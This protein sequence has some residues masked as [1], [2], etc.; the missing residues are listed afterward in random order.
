MEKTPDESST[1]SRAPLKLFTY[2]NVQWIRGGLVFKAHRLLCHSS[3]GLRVIKKKKKMKV[4]INPHDKTRLT[5]L[6]LRLTVTE[7]LKKGPVSI[8]STDL[9]GGVIIPIFGD[10]L[11]GG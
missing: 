4:S 10:R 1:A 5:N 7:T 2:R 8:Y 3:L 9:C 6:E 11:R